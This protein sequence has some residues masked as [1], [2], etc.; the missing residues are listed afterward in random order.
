MAGFGSQNI[1]NG[2]CLFPEDAK[3]VRKLFDVSADRLYLAKRSVEILSL[4]PA[5]NTNGF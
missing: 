1:V 2:Y 4:M 5:E 3:T